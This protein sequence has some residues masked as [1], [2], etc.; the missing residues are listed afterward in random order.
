MAACADQL[1]CLSDAAQFEL[2]FPHDFIHGNRYLNGAT[3]DLIDSH[4]VKNPPPFLPL[5]YHMPS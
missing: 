3:R 5:L 2:G 4:R 1:K